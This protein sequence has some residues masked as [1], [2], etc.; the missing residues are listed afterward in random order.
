MEKKKEEGCDSAIDHTFSIPLSS[1]TTNDTYK[2]E[3]WMGN[4]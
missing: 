3:S 4:L 1:H 2:Q